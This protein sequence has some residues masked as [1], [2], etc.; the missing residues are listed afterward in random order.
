MH[1]AWFKALLLF[2][3][4]FVLE[5]MALAQNSVTFRVRMRVKIL[6]GTFRPTRGDYV[7]VAGSFNDWG[8]SLDTLKDLAPIDSIYEKAVN[9]ATTG[10][11]SYKFLARRN[12]AGPDTLDW[13]SDPNRTYTVVAGTQSVPLVWFDN[14]SVVSGPP[15]NGNVTF[16]VNMRVKMQEGSFRPDSGDIVRVAGS[17]NDWGNS[18]DTLR[19][20]APTDSVYQKTI[21]VA[22]GTIGYKFLKTPNRGGLDWEGGDNRAYTVVGGDQTLPIVWFNYDSLV[23]L[24]VSGNITYRVDMRGLQ[25]IGWFVPATDSVQ[26]RG[27]FNGW[28]GTAMTLSAVTGFYQVTLPYSGFSFDEFDF[29]YFMKLDSAAAEARFPGFGTNKDGVQYDHPVERGD[30]N[31]RGQYPATSGNF[32]LA[33]FYFSN[34]NSRGNLRNAADTVRVTMRVNMGPAMRY[35]D[36]FVPATDTVFLQWQDQ[37]WAYNQVFNQ[38]GAAFP[39]R[40][41]MTRQGATDSIWTVSFRVKGKTHYGMIY[42]YDFRHAGTGG[43]SEGG[44]LGVQN[45]YRARFIQPIS[46]NTFPATYTAPV[47]IW[48][49]NGPMPSEA[50]PY[51]SD[52]DE[53]KPG[54]PLAYALD[55]NYPNPF[56][57]STRIAYSLPENAK[58]TLKVFN[59]LGQQVADLVNQ[60]QTKGNYVAVFEGQNLAT[61]VYFYRLETKNF[62]QVKKMI[63]MK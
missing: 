21:S 3:V 31:R 50:L 45:P 28:A 39:L 36:P 32:S 51:T 5:G 48:Q 1:K 14:D 35:I 52:I 41:R 25:D 29:K 4:V 22:T 19:D 26:V 24:P 34:I 27:G 57:P 49:K 61:G 56:N 23:S 6:E 59:I 62:S 16:R 38:G 60:D 7:R 17:F 11:V 15:T 9:I 40:L 63:L 20:V 47:D 58:V 12:P 30:G 8:N 37:A 13:E 42:N 46:P 53:N 18:R 10:Q 2:A 55:Q 33:P 43:V 44:G 54:V